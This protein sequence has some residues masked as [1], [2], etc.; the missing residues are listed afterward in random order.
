MF[1]SGKMKRILF[2]AVIAVI[3]GVGSIFSVGATENIEIP[4]TEPTVTVGWS[5]DENGWQYL[6]ES[7]PVKSQEKV[8]D[9]CV[10]LFDENGYLVT[11]FTQ[12]GGKTYY[13]SENGS[14]PENGYGKKIK[15]LVTLDSKMYYFKDDYSMSYGWQTIDGKRYYFDTSTGTAYIGLKK[16]NSKIY[17]FDK[18]RIM[19]K[20]WVGIS[21]KKYYFTYDGTMA[22]GIRKIS[23]HYYYFSRYG[24]MK[25]GWKNVKGRFYYFSANGTAKTGLN[26]VSGNK[27]YFSCTG[28]LQTG[29]KKVSGKIYYFDKRGALGKRGCGYRGFKKIGKGKYYFNKNYVLKTGI[30]KI[31]KNNYFLS[32]KGTIGQGYGKMKTGWQKYK[33]NYY[34]AKSNGI[35]IKNVSYNG[36][37]FD[38]NCALTDES[39]NVRKNVLKT[40]KEKTKN[41]K[42][43]QGKLYSLYQYVC[44]SNSYQRLPLGMSE[45]YYA[46]NMFTYHKG[47]CYAYASQFA[48]LAREIGYS[49]KVVRGYCPA[50]GGGWTPHGWCE[51]NIS[52]V[53]Y[54]FDPDL[55]KELGINSYMKTYYTA[56]ISY[57]K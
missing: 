14:T 34:F 1:R 45:A 26:N 52:G 19:K 41:I 30:Q 50:Y 4:T 42:S 10:Y 55:Q 13:Y 12:S 24:V 56:G 35:L 28:V 43:K 22:T 7:Y 2:V 36:Y 8:I 15:G 6:E 39:A 47:N 46:N 53:T 31:G 54:I 20:G 3:L 49:V 25:T 29:W 48:F 17:Y 9:G 11:G 5:S 27:F 37:E 40:V 23:S 38:K 33:G 21:G 51:I 18:N 57:K 44:T 32:P 16:I